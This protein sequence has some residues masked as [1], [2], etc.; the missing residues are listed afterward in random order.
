MD[1]GKGVP[2]R[3]PDDYTAAGGEAGLGVNQVADLL[4]N[5]PSPEDAGDTQL[6]GEQIT[7]YIRGDYSNDGVGRSFRD[8]GEHRLGDI[9]HS[10]PEYVG[11]PAASYPNLIEGSENPYFDF[12]TSNRK[13]TPIVYVG[14]NDGMLHAFH[15][16]TGEEY[17]SFIPG[18]VFSDADGEGLHALAEPNYVH[19]AYVDGGPISKD[20]FIGGE[21]KTYLV[22]GLRAGGK[23]VF[24]LDV[25]NPEDL[26]HMTESAA[27]QLVVTE[28][29]DDDLGFSF[30]TPQIAKMNNRK[31][32]AIFGNGYNS[33]PNGDGT[34]K[35][36][37]LYLDGSGHEVF[38]TNVGSIASNDCAHADS[39]CN[40]MSSPTLVDMNGDFRVDRIYSGDV[41]GNLWAF[42]VSDEDDTFWASS[43]GG[44]GSPLPLFSACE[45]SCNA[46]NR[47]PITAKPVVA[48]HPQIVSSDSNPNLIVMFGTGQFIAEDDNLNGQLQT[49]YGVWDNGR[50]EGTLTRSSLIEQD[51]EDNS[52]VFPGSRAL[53][54]RNV[55][56]SE[57]D[58]VYGWLIDLN[59]STDTEAGERLV[60]D[61]LIAG[62]FVFFN[63]TIPDDAQC[64]AGG[65]GFLMVANIL[66]GG[67]PSQEVFLSYRGSALN[68]VVAGLPMDSIPGGSVIIGDQIV[69]S[70]SRGE[71]ETFEY[72]RGSG[73]QSRRASWTVIK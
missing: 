34:A 48:A 66:N 4:V 13:R 2:F 14:A 52:V 33:D 19:R 53:T 47:Q 67:M 32:A 45:S 35:L 61:P 26:V 43:V 30:S 51:I 62:P 28:F 58:N 9:V 63:T 29:T 41:H 6:Y 8:R 49:L 50:S 20:V 65:S 37:V 38:E 56:Y 42:D 44:S 3:F 36:F 55:P 7:N 25:T 10:S 46:G 17:F 12:V 1:I 11:A 15:A 21:W 18:G 64:S 40:G 23:S 72:A 73:N 22:G 71:I 27:E 24:V 54:S 31:W 16:L 69:V 68:G 39:D 5:A 60:V 70:N 59:G 57:A